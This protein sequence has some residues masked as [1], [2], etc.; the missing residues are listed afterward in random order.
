MNNQQ[1]PQALEIEK[2]VLAACM[3]SME[4]AQ[5][6]GF[7]LEP[8]D[9]YLKKHQVTFQAIKELVNQGEAIDT[10]ILYEKIKANGHQGTVTASYLAKILDKDPVP[11]N[12]E[13]ACRILKEKAASRQLLNLCQATLQGCYEGKSALDLME[14]AQQGIDAAKEWIKE[15]ADQ[16]PRSAFRLTQLSS[17]EMR[18]PDWII[19]G[20]IERN[21]LG[22][23]F[24]DPESLKSFMAVGV[25]GSIGTASDFHGIPVKMS[26]P[27][28][29]FAAEGQSGIKRRFM[30]WAIRHQINIDDAPIY[31]STTPANLS[32]P[33]FVQEVLSAIREM[34]K[35]TGD[36]GL[37]VIDTV[38]RNFGP[39]DENSTQDMTR[40][41]AAT[42][43]I[44]AE[45][46]AAILLIHHSGHGD[47]SRARGAMALKGALDFEYRMTRTDNQVVMEC[48]KMKDAPRP[49]PM[50]FEIRTVELGVYDEDGEPV[51]SAILDRV[52]YA[53]PSSPAPKAGRGRWQ[54]TAM[55][56]LHG[57]IDQHRENLAAGGYDPDQAR[58]LIT[59][60]QAECF[61]AGM[62]R[63][64]FYKVKKS[65]ENQRSIYTDQEHV[66]IL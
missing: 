45:T 2:R 63:V 25:A 29:F 58:V 62:D 5:T 10:G 36:P 39:G 30:A 46:G 47:K 38:A 42:D 7:L 59:D 16:S 34:Q 9:F 17:L 1:P 64:R 23:I 11:A 15:I 18:S 24:G 33:D 66:S 20:Y 21:S 53:G 27:V 54:L 6:A 60:W 13:T 12:I 8:S 4:M 44:R 50:A 51:T 28:A 41:I 40:F 43:Q 57:L 37:I 31:V 22:L 3:L 55:R 48:T 35:A 19:P 32:D 49:D 56:I 14:Q 52:D 65:L 26:Q 61:E